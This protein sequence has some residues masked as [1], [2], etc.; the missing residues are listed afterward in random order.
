MANLAMLFRQ[1]EKQLT[2]TGLRKTETQE[3]LELR[4]TNG[5]RIQGIAWRPLT[6]QQVLQFYPPTSQR[7]AFRDGTSLVIKGSKSERRYYDPDH[8]L[9][10]GQWSYIGCP[11]CSNLSE[12]VVWGWILQAYEYLKRDKELNHK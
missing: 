12:D 1:A 3:V 6:N 4:D 8:R 9:N 5:R 10:A 2:D 11:D 7:K